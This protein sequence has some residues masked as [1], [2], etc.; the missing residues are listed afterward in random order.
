MTLRAIVIGAG[1]A[2]EG[3]TKAL[4]SA[5]IEVTAL[6]GRTPQPAQAMAG[7]LGIAD[8]RFDWRE[9]LSALQPDIV[10]VAT[11]ASAHL[12][13]VLAASLQG[14][15]I[16]CE[17]PLGLDAAQAR[18]MLQAV[19]QAGVKHGYCATSRYAPA[20]VYAQTLLAAGLIGQVQE[21]EVIH[22]FN[23]SPL[24]PYSWFFQLSQGGGALY[25]DFPH[26][27]EYVL[28]ITGGKLQSVGGAAR[29][30]IDRVP[31][32]PPIHDLRLA[33]VPVEPAQAKTGEWQAVDA[34]MGY[35]VLGRL[36]LP[37][38]GAASVL[39]QASEMASGRHPNSLALYGDKG[40]LHLGGYFFS[41]TIEYFDRV[42]H[43]WQEIQIPDELCEA[44]AW[45]EDLVQ[46]AWHQFM[47]E[48][49]ADVRG[50]GYAG[51][52]TFYNGWVANTVIDIV[53]SSQGWAAIPEWP[54]EPG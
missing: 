16:V 41:Q 45:T 52:P 40:S 13:I 54:H 36:R 37:D 50:E 9:A 22:H 30:L 1:W 42:Q 25:T 46:S 29:R 20:A 21:I 18:A 24:S 23:T 14:C 17:K 6:C 44:L 5:G 43:R 31:V 34:D 33:F 8:V 38:D 11:P 35:T 7:K 15:H 47:R 26:F 10:S 49:V 39:W 28:F 4:R 19:E 3:H 12:E 51:Y 27:L 53:R 48:F 2:G 32:G